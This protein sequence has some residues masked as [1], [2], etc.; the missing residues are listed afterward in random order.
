M[1]AKIKGHPGL[2]KDTNSGAVL[3]TNTQELEEYKSKKAAM[4]AKRMVDD[5]DTRIT[6]LENTIDEIKEL[7]L[8]ALSNGT[9]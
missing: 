7:L 1:K 3:N 6:K 9:S 2:L 8:K 5:V 4:R